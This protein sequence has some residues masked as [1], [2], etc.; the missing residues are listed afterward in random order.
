MLK[1]IPILSITFMFTSISTLS[2]S[3]LHQLGEDS[4][5]IMNVYDEKLEPCGAN[6]MNPGSWDSDYKCTE[7]FGG[8]HQICIENIA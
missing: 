7:Q 8:V 1:N 5:E 4:D 3:T 2:Y 6:N